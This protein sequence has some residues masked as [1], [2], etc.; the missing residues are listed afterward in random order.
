MSYLEYGCD[1]VV[2]NACGVVLDDSFSEVCGVGSHGL[3]CAYVNQYARR[4][5][6]TKTGG[7]ILGVNVVLLIWTDGTRVIPVA[8]RIY[9]GKG[10]GKIRLALELLEQAKALGFTPEYVLFDSWY[11]SQTVLAFVESL[12]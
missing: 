1:V 12:G 5:K 9:S 10:V 2:V 11:A 8:F 7:F 6:D 4:C 3:V